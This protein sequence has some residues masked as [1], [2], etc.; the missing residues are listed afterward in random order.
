M[1]L[2]LIL[3][4]FKE[5]VTDFTAIIKKT[6][7]SGNVLPKL[8]TAALVAPVNKMGAFP[9]FN[10]TMGEMEGWEKI[11]GERMAELI[12]KRGGQSTHKGCLQCIID[13]S[14]RYV[15]SQGQYLTGSL[16]YETIWSMGGMT[17]IKDLD[18]IAKLDFLCDDIGLDTMSAGAA[19]AVAMDAGYRKFGDGR[20]ALSILE[21]I[22]EGT[23]LGLVFGKGP[24][25]VGEYFGNHRIPVVKNQ[26]IAGYDPRA[27]Q[28][29]A[30]TYATSPMGADH[31]AGNLIGLYTAGLMDPLKKEGQ[32]KASQKAQ[33][34]MAS[35]DCIGLCLFTNAAVSN[36][37][38]QMA[39]FKALSAKMGR[40]FSLEDFMSLG[41]EVLR[42]ELEFNKKAGLTR[43]DNSLPPFF[44][45][46]SLPPH[47]QVVL[48]GEDEMEDVFKF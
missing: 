6:P 28:G 39:L 15:D 45:Q 13:C 20:S 10:A 4:A 48:I 11:S 40:E 8:G 34:I 42:I 5:A 22:A 29:L 3:K 14:N 19:I 2:Y 43:K 37:D 7:F 23:D 41:R 12:Q 27:M 1:G 9:C 26:S 21:Q 32:V 36:P 24:A 30:V 31:T 18:T 33:V 17:G 44:Y 16:E 35:L 46:E 47:N 25:A 38:G